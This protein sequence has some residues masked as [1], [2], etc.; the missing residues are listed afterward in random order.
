MTPECD[1]CFSPATISVPE[2]GIDVCAECAA[3]KLRY[4]TEEALTCAQLAL[5]LATAI[6][7]RTD[8]L[9]EAVH[10][11]G[12]ALRNVEWEIERQQTK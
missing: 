8:C 4:L 2:G 10:C 6:N 12:G 1:Y 9:R 7:G 3:T 11:L 5:A